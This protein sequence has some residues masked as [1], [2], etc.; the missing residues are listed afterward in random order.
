MALSI[1]A[2]ANSVANHW[3]S[4]GA[5]YSLHTG[6]PGAAGTANEA[7]GGGYAR[8]ATTWGSAALGVVTGSQMVFPV[9]AGSYTYMCRWSGSTLL[10]VIDTTD[11]TVSPAGEAKVTPK[12][13]APY[14][15]PA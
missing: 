15:L 1:V 6:H 9:A 10:D 5:S 2:T 8:Q 4:L 13:T 12:Y 7:T 11:V 14:S 3:A